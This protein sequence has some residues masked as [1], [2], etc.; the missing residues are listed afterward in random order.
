[1]VMKQPDLVFKI[2]AAIFLLLVA[3]ANMITT[4]EKNQYAQYDET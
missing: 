3:T 2:D 4:C 1:M